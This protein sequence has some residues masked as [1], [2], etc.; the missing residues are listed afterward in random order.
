[1]DVPINLLKLL[2]LTSIALNFRS[3][4]CLISCFFEMISFNILPIII[5]K[6][7]IIS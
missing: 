4:E 7:Y 2:N 6:W 3:R 5:T 1:M